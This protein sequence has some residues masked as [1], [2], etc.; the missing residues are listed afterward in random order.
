METI[1]RVQQQMQYWIMNRFGEKERQNE[2]S[3]KGSQ[4]IDIPILS[5]RNIEEI[6]IGMIFILQKII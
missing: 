5:R 6:I 4:Q 2:H 3:W 1:K